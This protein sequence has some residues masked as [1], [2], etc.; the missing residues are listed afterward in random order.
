MKKLILLL[1]LCSISFCQSTYKPGN[2]GGGGGTETSTGLSMPATFCAVTNSPVTTSGTLT[3]T[4]A[5][6][7]TANL[8]FGSD[9]SG[10]VGLMNL[11]ALQVPTL[12]QSTTGT[13]VNVTGVVALV[14]GGTGSAAGSAGAA[15]TALGGASLTANNTLSGWQ[16]IVVNSATN[17]ALS[18]NQ[19]NP[20]QN[21]AEFA[22]GG[23]ETF[24]LDYAG[25]SRGQFSIYNGGGAHRYI[26]LDSG[27]NSYIN[28][29]N[30]GIGSGTTPGFLFTVGSNLFT[31]AATTGDT[32]VA[33]ALGV[34][35]RATFTVAPVFTDQSGTRSA[36]SLVASATTDTTNA[37]N[38]SSG[39][40]GATYL[41]ATA[42]LNNQANT[43]GAFTE[44]FGGPLQVTSASNSYF[45]G[46]GNFG[47]GTATP[48]SLF[49]VGTDLLTVNSTGAT[50][51]VSASAATYGFSVNQTNNAQ[52]IAQ[53][54]AAGTQTVTFDYSGTN[55]GQVSVYNAGLRGLLLD[56]GGSSYFNGGNFGIGAGTTP[57]SLFTVGAN[58]FTVAASTGNTAVA[59][60]LGV[61][62][63][64]TLGSASVTGATTLTGAV[65]QGAKTTT[66]NNI[67]TVQGGIPSE[68][69]S[70]T[71]TGLTA[72]VGNSTLYVVPATA[73][74]LYRFS[75]QSVI[76]TAGSSSSTLPAVKVVFT[77]A[78]SSV[79]GISPSVCATSTSNTVGTVAQGANVIS[80]LGGT[81]IQYSTVS[82]ASSTAGM[83]YAIKILLEAL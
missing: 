18:V 29:G 71:T 49:T 73:A 74:F 23:L 80:V 77:N 16:S 38:I 28:G 66:Y 61:T 3:C 15:L 34:T 68:V 75:C 22:A 78:E 69:A 32:A 58:L 53:F 33:G 46:G 83:T 44:I 42:V 55:R 76:T 64:S 7:Q 30:F 2:G 67:A 1:S 63:L 41:P 8:I 43:F 11:T 10:N 39:T 50:A 70:I 60:T 35:G 62:G 25:T 31:V 48:G 4:Y 6:G 51:I 21:I 12:N 9:G 59:G 27:G 37:S 79:T 52:N 5:T 65:I 72:N 14:N 20:A 56:S 26:M 82:Y 54:L 45:T 24:S 81:T 40:L 36:L 57:G 17:Y 19:T 47:V 13:A